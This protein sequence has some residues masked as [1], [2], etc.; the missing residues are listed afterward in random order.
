MCVKLSNFDTFGIIRKLN[1]FGVMIC[2]RKFLSS[3]LKIRIC[4]C[5]FRHGMGVYLGYGKISTFFGGVG[6]CVWGGVNNQYLLGASP[7]S[8]KKVKSTPTPPILRPRMGGG[9]GT[10]FF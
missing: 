1:I 8:N 5:H 7:C 6:G 10:L 9:G 2:F 3:T 4:V